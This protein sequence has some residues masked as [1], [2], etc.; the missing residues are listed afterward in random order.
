M[1][2]LGPVR[3]PLQSILVGLLFVFLRIRLR[4]LKRET[5]CLFVLQTEKLNSKEVNVVAKTNRDKRKAI[6]DSGLLAGSQGLIL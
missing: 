3:L 6:L 5:G 4:M 1:L 2:H